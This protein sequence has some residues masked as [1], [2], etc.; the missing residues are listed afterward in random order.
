MSDNNT[1]LTEVR[2]LI[3]NL[4]TELRGRLPLKLDLELNYDA[5]ERLGYIR[6]ELMECQREGYMGKARLDRIETAAMHGLTSDFV[7]VD[8]RLSNLQVKYDRLLKQDCLSGITV[9]LLG[10]IVAGLELIERETCSAGYESGLPH[11]ERIAAD[12]RKRLKAQL[13]NLI[14]WKPRY[15]SACWCASEMYVEVGPICPQCGGS[16]KEL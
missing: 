1:D 5:V 2:D 14:I 15:G 8:V 11:V 12:L 10:E 3:C 16:R 13:P 7:K 4:L 9:Q 6:R